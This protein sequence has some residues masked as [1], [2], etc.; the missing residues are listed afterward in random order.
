MIYGRVE[1]RLR[2][3]FALEAADIEPI[4]EPFAARHRHSM[5]GHHALAGV[6]CCRA[7]T[8]EWYKRLARLLPDIR[9]KVD[10][11]RV[12]GAPHALR[13]RVDW[14]SEAHVGGRQRLNSGYHDFRFTGAKITDLAIFCDA[15]L[16]AEALDDLAGS[17][18][19]EARASPIGVP[20]A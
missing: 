15:G 17:G 12:W 8:R 2:A 20:Y 9:F 7:E 10:N 11:I 6:R 13:A 18:I 14:Q 4:L 3:A 16:F 19:G 1:T 5:N